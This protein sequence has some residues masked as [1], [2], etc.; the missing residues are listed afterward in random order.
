MKAQL[1]TQVNRIAAER[2]V[3]E[4]AAAQATVEQ[5][6]RDESAAVQVARRTT[7]DLRD[8]AAAAEQDLRAGSPGR[9]QDA[10]QAQERE[11]EV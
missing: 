4:A 10:Q 7:R 1:E 2:L 11:L 5:R 3:Q 6:L 8:E 9:L